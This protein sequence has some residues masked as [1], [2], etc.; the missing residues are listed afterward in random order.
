MI[1]TGTV[2]KSYRN[3]DLAHLPYLSNLKVKY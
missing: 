2:D 3:I 1:W